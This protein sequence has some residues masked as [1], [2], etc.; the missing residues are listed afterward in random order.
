MLGSLVVWV[1]AG[2]GIGVGVGDCVVGVGVLDF[3]RGT[4]LGVLVRWGVVCVCDVSGVC[5]VLVFGV[6]VFGALSGRWGL[7]R[8]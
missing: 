3:G 1:V 6:L 7:R 4:P 5:M 2:V 8:G